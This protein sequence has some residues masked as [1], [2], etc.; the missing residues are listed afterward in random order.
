MK[1][2]IFGAT[3]S[4]GRHLVDQAL[5]QGHNVTAFARNPA[6]L[7]RHH[8]NLTGYAGDVRDAASVAGAVKD[9]DAVM[10]ALGAGRKGGVRSAGT[11]NVIDAM[12][13]HGV[14]RLVCETTLGAGDSYDALNFFWK[15]LM[16][17]LLLRPAFADH[18]AQEIHIR[19][20]DLDWIIVRPAAFTDGPATT[21]YMHGFPAT[22]KNLTFKISRADVAGFMLRQ[23]ADDTY[24]RQ[25]PGLSYVKPAKAPRR[26]MACGRGSCRR[27]SRQS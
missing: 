8:E 13:A 16:F 26:A 17:G 9:H 14:K 2:I 19:N 23:I 18:Q 11:K 25:T 12:R 1:I 24:L 10:I 21:A 22:E 3:G 7:D 27:L 5:T 15:R 20:S 4:I 6:A